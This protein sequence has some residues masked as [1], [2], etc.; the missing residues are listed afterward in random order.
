M[1]DASVV[2]GNCVCDH[3]G[4]WLR[5]CRPLSALFAF[6]EAATRTNLKG[7]PEIMSGNHCQATSQV[8][9]VD[10]HF[11]T[12]RMSRAPAIHSNIV[13]PLAVTVAAY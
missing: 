7:W 10:D 4:D 3:R 1:V 12:H 5:Q 11:G 9:A 8:T 13:A 2:R 6:V